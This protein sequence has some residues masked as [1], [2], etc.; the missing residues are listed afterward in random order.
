MT[1][2]DSYDS[3]TLCGTPYT[4]GPAVAH[5]KV[6][7]PGCTTCSLGSKVGGHHPAVCTQTWVDICVWE[8]VSRAGKGSTC[9]YPREWAGPW[10]FSLKGKNGGQTVFSEVRGSQ[11]KLALCSSCFCGSIQSYLLLELL[12]RVVVDQGYR[13]GDDVVVTY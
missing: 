11:S 4:Y 3:G 10:D 5:R 6:A 7:D 13:E 1:L 12:C 2:W 9:Q 8:G